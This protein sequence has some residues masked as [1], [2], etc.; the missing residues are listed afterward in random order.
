MDNLPPNWCPRSAEILKKSARH[1]TLVPVL[2]TLV[3]DTRQAHSSNMPVSTSPSMFA[4]FGIE[5]PPT[6]ERR[7]FPRV[8]IDVEARL[9]CLNPLTSTGPSIKARVVEISRAGMKIRANREFQIGGVV[10]VIVKDMFYMATVRHCQ[11]L[12]EGFETGLKL[13][14]SIRSSLL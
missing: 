7:R 8:K 13:T 10:Q 14:E 11:K 1:R 12:D 2:F 3:P 5:A 9:K 4:D 6:E